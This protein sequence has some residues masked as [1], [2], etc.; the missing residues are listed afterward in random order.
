MNTVTDERYQ[1]QVTNQLINRDQ[2][3]DRIL[4]L[5]RWLQQVPEVVPRSNSFGSLIDTDRMKKEI[6]HKVPVK[7][8]H[9]VYPKTL[10]T[11]NV[12]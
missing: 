10:E 9:T 5:N 3:Y 7:V 2:T 4:K 11:T 12:F 8:K 1:Q 6:N